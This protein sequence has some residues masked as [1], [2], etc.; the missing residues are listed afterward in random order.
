MGAHPRIFNENDT[1]LYTRLCELIIG[2]AALRANY[3]VCFHF[4][5]LLSRIEWYWNLSGRTL[6]EMNWF[7]SIPPDYNEIIG[8]KPFFLE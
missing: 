3:F 5:P 2:K 7:L 1:A 8:S 4:G 6:C